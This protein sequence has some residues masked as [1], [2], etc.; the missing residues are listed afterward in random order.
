MDK[1][2][3]QVARSGRPAGS[4]RRLSA[5][6]E[7]SVRR[8]VCQHTPDQLDMDYALWS[9]AAVAELI[10]V[11]CGL[12]LPVR[13]MGLYLARWG[14]TPPKSLRRAYEQSPE[15]VRRWLRHDHPAIAARARAE[16]HWGDETVLR[17]D[18]VCGRRY[19]PAGHTPAI[20]VSHRREA[21]GV[22]CSFTNR[23]TMRWKRLDGALDAAQLIDFM[24]RLVKDAPAKVYLILDNLRVHHARPV[25][26]WRAKHASQIEVFY[27]PRYAPELSPE[28]LLNA[29]LKRAVATGY[30]DAQQRRSAPRCHRLPAPAAEAARAHLALLRACAGSL[31]RLSPLF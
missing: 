23:G 26:A 22:I 29:D 30:V 6:Q 27:L 1:L 12:V 7:A 19:A 3:E 10:Q 2:H 15:A 11:R 8:L 28:E 4:G 9:R 31:C 14:F 13:T 20:R 16:I 25:R 24:G 18:D 5:A 17:S 21:A